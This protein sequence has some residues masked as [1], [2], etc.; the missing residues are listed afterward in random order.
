MYLKRIESIGFKSFAEKTVIEFKNGITGVVG[1]NGSGKSNI[2]DAIR[3]VLGEQSAKTLRG[4]KMEDVIFAGTSKRRPLGYAEV[5]LVL[6]NKDGQ[7]PIDYS[8]VSITRR[9]FRSGES[10]YYINKTSCRL[11]D[12]RELFMDTGVGKDGYSIIGQGRIDEILSTKSEDRR[13][14]FEEAAGIVKYKTR[15]EEAEKKLEKTNENLIRINDIISELDS[16]IEPLEEQS[17]KAEQYIKY[18]EKLKEL[19]VNLFVREIDRLKEQISHIENQRNLIESQLKYNEDKRDELE[20]KY[21]QVKNE[22]EKMD[23]N[24]ETVQNQ[25]YDTQNNIE[26]IEGEINLNSEKINIVKNEMTRLED[27]KIEIEQ[28]IQKIKDEKRRIQSYS[29]ELQNKLNGLNKELEEKNEVLSKISSSIVEKERDIEEKKGDVIELFNLIADRKSKINSI[30]TFNQNIEKR[31]RQIQNEIDDLEK[32]K[33]ENLDNLNKTILEIDKC[34]KKLNSLYEEK[35]HEIVNKRN[36]EDETSEILNMLN[37]VKENIHVKESKCNLLKD[38]KNEYEGFYKSVKNTLIAVKNDK[39]LGRGV[40]GVVAELVKVGKKF[41]RAIEV[42]LGSSLQNIVTETEQD[43]KSI[44]NYLKKNNLGR[45]TFL[46]MTSIKG[47][48]LNAKERELIKQKGLVGIGSELISF[49]AQ[50]KDIFN[51]LLGRVVVVETIDAGINIARLCNFSFK[52]VSLDGDVINP[53]GS[54]TGGSY[55]SNYTNILGRERQ[56]EELRKEILSLKGKKNS[57]ESKLIVIKDKLKA[58]DLKLDG[59]D[60]EIN[61]LTINLT[62]LENKEMQENE[63]NNKL[64]ERIERYMGEKEQLI[65]EKDD[66]IEN[67]ENIRKELEE[68]KNRNDLTQGNIDEMLKTFDE[69]K[70][71]RDDLQRQLTDIRIKAASYEQEVKS[72]QDTLEKLEDDETRLIKDTQSKKNKYNENLNEINSLKEKLQLLTEKKNNFKEQLLELDIKVKEIK[73]DKSKYLQTFYAEQEKIN[74]MNRK[75]N[76]LQKSVTTLDVKSTKYTT[77]LESINSKLW[78]EYE[79]TYQ[80]ALKHK[81]DIESITKVQNEIKEIKSKIKTLGNVNLGSIEEYKR[82]KER[83]EFL[84]AQEEDLINAK[85]SLNKV[86]K[87]MERKMKEQFKEKFEVIRNNFTEIF[88]KLFGGGKSDIYLV[89][90]SDIL[91]SGIEILAQPPGKKLQNI[92][93]LSGGEKALTAIALLFAIL[94]TKP[95]PFC[96]LDEIEA[97]LDDANVYRF[98]D[99]LREFSQETQ[100]IVITHR[101]GTMESVDALY[102]VT[103]EEEGVSKLVSVKLTDKL[104]E[105]AS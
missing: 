54:M 16:Q 89:D 65:K 95:T 78:D 97:A 5:T 45:V 52:I 75:I 68:L 6:D 21:N 71:K 92:S 83:Y 3:W 10:E 51:Y 59:L 100:F 34:K 82:V 98:A 90:E 14:I 29:S 77:Q 7:L 17:K 35:K 88:V 44:I 20:G 8:E 31:I 12:I 101:K 70:K 28:R 64:I 36:I 99:Y 96:V 42:A 27:E 40:R 13:N 87:D 81:K 4:S 104:T 50:Y 19:E 24:I 25:K 69:E 61:E 43:A 67:M 18:S 39:S 93:L 80:M 105:K 23:N 63:E 91:V 48:E 41:E 79:L 55:N 9:L 2:S 58:T 26:K 33:R 76:D 74:E 56:I 11:K 84:K 85:A 72:L 1:P 60:A 47:R 62:K 94:K 57:Y 38:M 15:K 46:P 22:I 73:G 49:D 102:G 37:D 30:D 53:G 66:S 86:I 103:M 32:N